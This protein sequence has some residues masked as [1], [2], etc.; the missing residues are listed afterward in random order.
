MSTAA[1]VVTYNGR[2]W[3]ERC[4]QSLV[5]EIDEVK[6]WVIDNNSDDD[7]ASFVRKFFP[8]VDLLVLLKNIGFGAANHVGIARSLDAG[9]ERIPLL[10]QDAWM[11]SGSLP[12][13]VQFMTEHPEFSA[14]APLHCSPDE[15]QVDHKTLANY[16]IHHGREYLADSIRG[17]VK[18]YY[19]VH[20][21]NA[22]IWLVD[23]ATWHTVGGFDPLFFMYGEDDDWLH[24]LS[25]HKLRFALVPGIRGVHLRQ[26]P[27]SPE[28]RRWRDMVVKLAAWEYSRLLLVVK[29]PNASKATALLALMVRGLIEPT[30]DCA[31]DRNL[32]RL[33]SRW[34]AFAQLLGQLTSV[35]GS[36]RLVSS[37]GPSF[38]ALSSENSPNEVPAEL[39]RAERNRPGDF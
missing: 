4:L 18:E 28:V 23:S 37:K 22:A 3:I 31:I 20:G 36:N 12:A 5:S 30:L 19:Q 2:P 21:V 10:D 33:S 8:T 34:L 38:L 15:S 13:L 24:R 16:L 9:A 29:R 35:W 14:C 7:T 39:T 1:V 11:P 17:A 6:V 32:T 26:S 25:F 27:P